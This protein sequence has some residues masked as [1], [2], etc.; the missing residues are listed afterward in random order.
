[1]QFEEVIQAF[2]KE[3]RIEEEKQVPQPWSIEITKDPAKG[4]LYNELGD[5]IIK[6]FELRSKL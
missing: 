1:M 5:F 3:K 6:L 4:K 2:L